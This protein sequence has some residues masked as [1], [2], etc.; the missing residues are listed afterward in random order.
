[1]VNILLYKV[2]KD[3][4]AINGGKDNEVLSAIV[5]YKYTL[6]VYGRNVMVE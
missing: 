5:N 1:M 2:N 6:L 4:V 3:I